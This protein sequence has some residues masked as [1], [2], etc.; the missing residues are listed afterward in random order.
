MYILPPIPTPPATVRAPVVVL[1]LDTVLASM[2][3]PVL[4][5]P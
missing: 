3:L 5:V 2:I 1:T 4:N